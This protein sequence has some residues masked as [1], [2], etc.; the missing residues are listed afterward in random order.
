MKRKT[1]REYGDGG[2]L[3]EEW[4]L[5]LYVTD[6]S[7]RCTVAYKNLKR[8]CSERLKDRFQIEVI[9]LLEHPED[10]RRE[11]IVAI[12]TLMKIT[13]KPQRIL[14]G[15]FSQEQYVVKGL[16]MEV[17]ERGG[18]KLDAKNIRSGHGR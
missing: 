10:A 14:V 3:R 11:Q 1:V 4:R 12:P 7:P 13:P 8:I 15:D 6:W 16:D 18:T 5:R 17:S 2:T 9:D